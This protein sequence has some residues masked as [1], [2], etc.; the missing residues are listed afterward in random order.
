MSHQKIFRQ[1]FDKVSSTYTYL[2]G[3][4]A[5]RSVILID[6]CQDCVERELKTIGEL[7]FQKVYLLN[8]HIHADHITGNAQLKEHLGSRSTSIISRYY[9]NA[10]ADQLV[11]ED[12]T[13]IVGCYKLNF[14]HT[15]GHT[16]GCLCIVDHDNRRVFTG[17]TL[18]IRGCGRTDFQGGSSEQ[19]YDSVHNK[20]FKLP[21][22]YT[23]YPAHDYNGMTA[24]S[25]DEE[26][27]F[28]RRL[29]KPKGEFI[30]IMSKLNLVYPKLIDVAVPQNLNCGYKVVS[31]INGNSCGDHNGDCQK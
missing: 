29:S 8:T 26:I 24:S 20:L 23:I 30:D 12:D 1:F 10:R 15:P 14:L 19:L 5:D 21:S 7:E 13:L 16:S 18:L 31:S 28:N 27:K 25:I 9:G 4:L 6:S 22:D 11:G 2:L 3:D 17:D